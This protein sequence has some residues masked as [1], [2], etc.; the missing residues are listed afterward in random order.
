MNLVEAVPPGDGTYSPLHMQEA[1]GAQSESARRQRPTSTAPQHPQASLHSQ[2]AP[3]ET[4]QLPKLSVTCLGT[5]RQTATLAGV[6][7]R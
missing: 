6:G 1:Q 5:R 7:S 3:S 4:G 2:A